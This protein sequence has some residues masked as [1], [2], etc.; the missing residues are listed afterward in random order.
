MVPAKDRYINVDIQHILQVE[1][2]ILHIH[3]SKFQILD[4]VL[5]ETDILVCFESK[6]NNKQFDIRQEN[7]STKINF[8]YI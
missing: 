5:H 1:L 3:V 6:N 8:N 7:I 4:M 2:E